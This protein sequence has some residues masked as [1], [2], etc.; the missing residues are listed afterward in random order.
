M[1]CG[2]GGSKRAPAG[3]TATQPRQQRDATA[4][5]QQPRQAGGHTW[6]G[7]QGNRAQSKR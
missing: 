1:G 4:V 6:N 7:P 2:C 5:P 3:V